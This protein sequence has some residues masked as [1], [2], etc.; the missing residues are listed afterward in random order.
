MTDTSIK[1]GVIGLGKMGKP[2]TRNLLKA[3]FTVT[4]NNRSTAAT[5][6]MVAAGAIDGGSP[7]GVA[8]AADIII[9]SL[10]D[11]TAVRTVY[12]EPD[13][14]V[15][16]VR[17]GQ[18]I[19]DTS[20]IDPG[21]SRELAEKVAAKNALFLDAPVSGGVAGAEAGT[22]TIMIGGTE[23]A[24]DKASPVLSA[25][26]QKLHLVGPN[27]SGTVI[28]LANQLLV[29]INMSAVAE[30]MVLGVKAG[31]DPVKMLEVLSTSFGGSRMLDRGVPLIV[32]RN[33][34][35]GTPVDLI[36]K[37]LGLISDLA[38]EL[39][40]PLTV[41]AEARAVFDRA[42]DADHGADDMTAVVLPMESVAEIE[43][44]RT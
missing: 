5:G 38:A 33:F 35:G 1:V 10:P 6:E 20:T 19:V 44:K 12:L 22:L 18:V 34:G 14:L 17:E 16:S 31:A 23:E 30:A 43:V 39:G 2:I 28:K 26:G 27:G 21:L 4:V 9:T 15:D 13:G 3:G 7:R 24:F 37:D 29:G 11:P 8:D 42:H 41:G 40:V 36:R 25:I 32:D